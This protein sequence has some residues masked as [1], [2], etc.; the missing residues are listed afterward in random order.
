MVGAMAGKRAYKRRGYHGSGL[1]VDIF[2]N[3]LVAK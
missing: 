1:Y 3:W 2:F